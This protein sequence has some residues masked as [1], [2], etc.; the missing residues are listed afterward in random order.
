M[1]YDKLSDRKK[2]ILSAVIDTY[3]DNAEPVSSSEIKNNYIKDLSSA[4]IRSE[5]SALEEMGY[6]IQP[7]TSS[8]RVPSVEA[9]R[10]YVERMMVDRTLTADELELIQSYFD[11]KVLE[12]DDIIKKTAKIISDVTNYTSVI[13]VDDVS[14]VRLRNIRLVDI[15]DNLLLIVIVTDS[16]I[17]SDKTLVYDCNSMSEED[18]IAAN[19]ILNKVFSGKMIKELKGLSKIMSEA[20][21]EYSKLFDE[22]MR[23]LCKYCSDNENKVY[24]EGTANIFNHK[25]YEDINETKNFISV[26]SEKNNILKLLENNKD[27]E[28]SVKIGGDKINGLERCAVVTSKYSI[29]GGRE[30][31]AGVI[32]PDRMDYNKVKAVLNYIGEMIKS[33]VDNKNDKN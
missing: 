18:I 31:K 19:A 3:I 24:L 11:S 8:G 21:G 7:H 12:V 15:V 23:I 1:D 13:L 22:I 28:F 25:E 14:S 26:I 10:Y 27:I 29:S 4:T 9:Y 20:V 32:G 5:L 30:V 33:I 16:G 17:I 2:K 6:L